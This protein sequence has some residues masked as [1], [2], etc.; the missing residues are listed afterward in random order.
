MKHLFIILYLLLSISFLGIGWTLDSLWQKHV[1]DDNTLNE[2]LLVLAQLLTQLPQDARKTYLEALPT[3][4]KFP[5]NLLNADQIALVKD[6]QLTPNK[7][8]TTNNNDEQF[9]YIMVGE[10]VLI[11]GPLN[12]DSSFNS[13]NLLKLF[14]YLSLALVALIWGTPLSRD[15]NI[16]RRAT[17]EFGEAKW[18]TRITLSNRS[19]VKPLANTFNEMA[20]H[21]SVLIENQKHFSNAISHEIRTPLARLKF[22]LALIPMYYQSDFNEQKRQ[23]FLDEMQLDIKEME[24]LLQRLLTYA[25]LESQQDSRQLDEYDLL[26]LVEQTI[27]RLGALSPLQINLQTDINTLPLTGEPALIE[28]ALQNLLTNA[29]RFARTKITI[30]VTQTPQRVMVSVC[31]NGEPI[32]EIDLPKIFEPFYRSQSKQNG[33]KGHGLGL[34]I[35]KRIMVRH[36]GDV[37]VTSNMS[38]TC[39]TLNWPKKREITP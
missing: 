19:L 25:S 22:A 5:L 11:A 7:I 32:P 16:L 13:L 28:H 37:S 6:K 29:Q 20:R 18:N 23:N 38:Q 12:I 2:P 17:K 4:P 26:Q 10:Q 15:L 35:I 8:I 39:F 9:Q 33:D 27:K 30:K 36:Q 3:N 14:L 21:I 24:N 31:N 34:A 1:D